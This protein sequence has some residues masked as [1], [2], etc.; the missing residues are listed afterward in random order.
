MALPGADAVV[1]MTRALPA[2]RRRGGC[3][4][5]Q[6]GCPS[7]R[8]Y[9]A[10]VKRGEVWQADLNGQRPIVV[11]GVGSSGD[12][13]RAIQIVAPATEEQ[14]RGCVLL[15]PEALDTAVADE[16]AITGV[17]VPLWPGFAVDRLT[18]LKPIGQAGPT[19]RTAE[20]RRPSELASPGDFWAG[21]A[22]TD[23]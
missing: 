11:L 3:A 13:V 10:G 6:P 21:K 19:E 7:E 9:G 2:D 18:A 12:E 15:D 17:E 4:T 5:P 20:C 16:V 22:E 14:K 1:T 8:A 23:F